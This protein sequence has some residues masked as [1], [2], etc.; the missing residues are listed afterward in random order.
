MPLAFKY[1]PHYT[2]EDYK[3]WE[4][5][6]ELIEGIPYAMAPSPFKKHQ[7]ISLRIVNQIYEQLKDCPANCQ[8]LYEIDWIVNKDTVV[9]P[10]ILVVCNDES[11]DF[12]RKTPSII[13]EIVSKATALKDENLKFELYEREG[14]NYYVLVYPEE[15]RLK[16]YKHTGSKFI[17]VFDGSSGKFTFEEF[18][19][20]LE[21][22]VTKVW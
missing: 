18:E 11:E 10:D 21:L 14:I 17:N 16:V 9:R 3:Q 22:E 15:K 20:P 4:G 12:V 5:D 13:F 8:V 7:L 1:L 6:W 19:C 2:Y